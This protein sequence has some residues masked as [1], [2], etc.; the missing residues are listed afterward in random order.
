MRMQRGAKQAERSV[1]DWALMASRFQLRKL[2]ARCE[3]WIMQNYHAA[4]SSKRVL[5]ALSPES[6][7]RIY[8]CGCLPWL[9]LQWPYACRAGHPAHCHATGAARRPRRRA[10][11]GARR[12]GAC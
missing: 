6:Q 7:L 3:L 1:L 9:I 8:K 12:A 4:P 5:A 11:R 2:T 10:R